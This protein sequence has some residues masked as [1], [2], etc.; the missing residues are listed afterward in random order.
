MLLINTHGLNFY[1][2]KKYQYKYLQY[3]DIVN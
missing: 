1:A 2:S 3:D